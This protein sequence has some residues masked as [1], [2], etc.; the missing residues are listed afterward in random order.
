MGGREVLREGIARLAV[1][2]QEIL[3]AAYTN[4]PDGDE[5]GPKAFTTT[6]PRA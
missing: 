4:H 1:T 2:I 6:T 5:G 3:F